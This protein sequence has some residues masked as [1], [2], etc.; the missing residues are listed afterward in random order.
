MLNKQ[1]ASQFLA[2]DALKGF[3]EKLKEKERVRVTRKILMEG[4]LQELNEKIH[5]LQKGQM[6]K[7]VYFD[8]D[9]YV[10]MQGLVAKID[11]LYEKQIQ[12]VQTKIALCDIYE[13][14]F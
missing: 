11:L 8:Q 5:N 3:R 2:F 14:F 7:I 6:V 10:E 12:I 1:R 13:I 4:H 9:D